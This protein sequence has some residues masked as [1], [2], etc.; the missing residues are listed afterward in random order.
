MDP[1]E[2]F[3][4]RP[5]KSVKNVSAGREIHTFGLGNGPSL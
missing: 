1:H 3:A 4:K 5:V 2:Q